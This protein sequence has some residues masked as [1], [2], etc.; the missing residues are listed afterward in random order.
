MPIAELVNATWGN[1][2]ELP[3]INNE[4]LVMGEKKPLKGGT[5]T[6]T[7]VIHEDKA[8]PMSVQSARNTTPSSSGSVATG[9]RRRR[10]REENESEVMDGW[11]GGWVGRRAN[12]RHGW[13]AGG[14]VGRRAGGRWTGGWAV[15]EVD[16][17]AG[18]WV[19]EKKW[20]KQGD[21]LCQTKEMDVTREAVFR[22]KK[23]CSS[24]TTHQVVSTD[25]FILL[26]H[27]NPKC[28]NLL[29]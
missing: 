2:S 3:I 10:N 29:I 6:E 28:M 18:G 20:K 5:R 4:G 17:W 8:P 19:G 1:G 16:V 15:H 21:R 24:T 7:Q 14:Q 12:G 25:F 23:S 26:S 11:A 22:G 13:R 27:S 9:Y